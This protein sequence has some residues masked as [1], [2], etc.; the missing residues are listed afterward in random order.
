MQEILLFE[1]TYNNFL[2][3]KSFLITLTQ[4]H[5]F[6]STVPYASLKSS[7]LRHFPLSLGE[8]FSVEGRRVYQNHLSGMLDCIRLP[9]FPQFFKSQ[10]SIEIYFMYP[11]IHYFCEVDKCIGDLLPHDQSIAYICHPKKFH[12]ALFFSQ[13]YLVRKKWLMSL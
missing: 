6:L 12:C 8:L 5:S 3:S 11:V 7:T 2:E 13:F 4:V 10:V 1:G 9:K